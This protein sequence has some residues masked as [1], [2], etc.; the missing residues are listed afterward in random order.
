MRVGRRPEIRLA[1]C[2]AIK[3]GGGGAALSRVS[4]LLF[5]RGVALDA[6][7]FV[8]HAGQRVRLR[9]DHCTMRGQ[10]AAQARGILWGE[11][12]DLAS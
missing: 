12:F 5:E 3:P 4:P 9:G 6:E 11:A 2:Q 7:F 8:C 10:R 1:S